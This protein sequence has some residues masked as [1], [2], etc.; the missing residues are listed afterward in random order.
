MPKHA[1]FADDVNLDE[2]ESSTDSAPKHGSH[3]A[4]PATGAV[5]TLP[6]IDSAPEKEPRRRSKLPW[7]I[8]P[9]V[10]VAALGGGY[11]Y[12]ANLYS[13]TFMPNTTV[14][15]IDVSGMT[16]EELATIV[17]GDISD[18]SST[19]TGLGLDIPLTAENV[20]LALDGEELAQ[21]A[22]SNQNPWTWPL[23]YTKSHSYEATGTITFDEN[24]LWSLIE[25]IVSEAQAEAD[26]LENGGIYYDADQD[27]YRV[28]DDEVARHI[29]QAALIAQ[30]SPQIISM[31]DSVTVDETCLDTDDS[32]ERALDQAN[33]LVGAT[34]DLKLGDE[35]AYTID[36][37]AISEWISFDD[38]LN[39]VLDEE[40][41]AEFGPGELSE[42][43]DTVGTTRN[44]TRPDGKE[45]TVTGG[46]YGWSIMGAETSDLILAAIKSGEPT[47]IDVPTYQEADYVNPGGQEW[48]RYIDV[49]RTE[50][51]ARFYDE[52]GN[53][54][55]ET[56]LVTGQPNLG[57][58]TPEGVWYVTSKETNVNLQGPRNEEGVPEWNS[59]VDF[60]MGV[61]EN[62]VGLHNAPWRAAF[63]GQ[64]YQWAGS[65]GCINMSYEAAQELYN[66]VEIGVPVIVHY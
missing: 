59:Y 41:I 61:V 60:W 30:A 65:H 48:G 5:A 9:A 6:T 63:G 26:A 44:F 17:E 24:K 23:E 53:I 28:Q 50:Q 55:W 29:N 42:T 35:V 3:F 47:T 1:H 57:H 8:V 22:M 20:G 32:V 21:S 43:L 34:I 62:R 39:V 27:C 15:G 33:A 49:D 2:V 45:I 58:E 64:I 31:A 13:K 7:L 18:W 16:P 66:L 12:G 54:I 11:A 40:A 4:T 38:D 14:N 46:S 56:D 36:S 51:Y 52:D 37:D 10:L 19:L 25:P